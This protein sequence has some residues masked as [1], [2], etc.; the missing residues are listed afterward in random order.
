MLLGLLA[1]ELLELDSDRLLLLALLLV[2]LWLLLEWE[3]ADELL[4]LE[5]AELEDDDWLL[6]LAEELLLLSSL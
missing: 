3:L 5:L 2:L 6:V 4:E 1:D